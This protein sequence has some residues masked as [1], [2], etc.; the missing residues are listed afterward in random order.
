MHN[1]ML[2]ISVLLHGNE[3]TGFLAVQALLRKYQTRTLPRALSVFFGNVSAAKTGVRRLVGQ[4]DY[5]RIW[6]GIQLSAC[7]EIRMASD[8]VGVMTQKPLFASV[9]I[10]NNTGLNPHYSCINKLGPQFIQ[11]ATLFGSFV[12]YFT[13]PKGC[14]VICIFPVLPCCHIR[15]WSTRATIQR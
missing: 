9:D 13:S 14:A 5:N 12:V 4:A 2:F 8:I 10:H 3:S 6:P 15:I 1:E 7:P 11:L